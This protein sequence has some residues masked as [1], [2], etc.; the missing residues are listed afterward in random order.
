MKAALL[1][2]TFALLAGCAAPA[3]TSGNAAGE[4]SKKSKTARVV[5]RSTDRTESGSE[6]RAASATLSPKVSTDARQ[7]GDWVTFAFSGSYRKAELTLTQRVLTKEEGSIT[8]EYAFTEGKK[9]ET[10]RVT[11]REATGEFL[12]ALSVAKDGST[13]PTD[14]EAFENKL[15]A[16]VAMA[17]ENDALVDE[18]EISVKVGSLQLPATKSTFAVKVGGQKATLE[19]ITSRSFAWGDL[20]GKLATSD[21]KVIFQVA[22][23]DAG[24]SA[25]ARTAAL[26]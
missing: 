24:S 23:V 14:Q 22:L 25:G 17:D 6:S 19:T 2:T 12:R 18:T 26:E 1:V 8:I 7:P 11:T 3:I 15:A 13:E 9:V 16:T 20:G 10:F 21:G 5:D 4:T